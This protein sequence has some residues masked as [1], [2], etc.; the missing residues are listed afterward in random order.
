MVGLDRAAELIALATRSAEA[1]GLAARVRFVVGD[2]LDPPAE[3]APGGFD[4]VMANPPFVTADHGSPP[5]D[6]AKRAATVEGRARLEDWLRFAL[7]M[8]RPGGSVTVIHRFDRRDEVI[9][10]L[11]AGG[12][13]D[14]AVMPLWRREAGKDAKRAIVRGVK[15][16]KGAPVNLPG[17][18][19]HAAKGGYTAAT[20]AVLTD[21][22]ALEF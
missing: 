15:G 9:A 17:L 21:A 18:V 6:A 4:H 20:A 8:S 14:I 5:A 22:R 11:A 3:L 16:G 12:A 7:S 13:G 1:S 2:L 19:L 10:G